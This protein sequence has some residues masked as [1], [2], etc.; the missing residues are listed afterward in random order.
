RVCA[1][2]SPGGPALDLTVP[3]GRVSAMVDAN[4][5]GKTTALRAITGALP[6]SAGSLEVVGTALGPARV[7]PPEGMASVPDIAAHPRH[8]TARHLARLR[9]EALPVFATARF[10]ELLTAFGLPHD[11]H[12]RI[13]ARP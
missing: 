4:S 7:R 11:P 3:T 8:W 6:F 12:V 2:A 9:D 13:H 1:D 5:A 10:E